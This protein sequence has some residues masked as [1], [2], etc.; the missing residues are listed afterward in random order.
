MRSVAFVFSVVLAAVC[1]LLQV[2]AADEYKKPSAPQAFKRANAVLSGKI[3]EVLPGKQRLRNITNYCC[4][5]FYN[6]SLLQSARIK[7]EKLYRR[8]DAFG[9]SEA[10]TLL[11]YPQAECRSDFKPG[12]DWLFY[13]RYDEETYSWVIGD[14][15]RSQPISE[16]ID[17]LMFFEKLPEALEKTRISGRV[18]QIISPAT[19]TT[20]AVYKPLA[21]MEIVASITNYKTSPVT[22]RKILTKTDANGFYEFY[23]LPNEYVG[24]DLTEEFK[25][26]NTETFG[27]S[28]YFYKPGDLRTVEQ[29]F[30]L[31]TGDSIIKGKILDENGKPAESVKVQLI[32]VGNHTALPNALAE[33]STSSD[34]SKNGE[35]LENIDI[36]FTSRL[37]EKTIS[38]RVFFN[39]GKPAE[40]GKVIFDAILNSKHIYNSDFNLNFPFPGNSDVADGKFSIDALE[41]ISG[42][43]QAELLFRRDVLENCLKRKLDLP[44]KEKFVLVNSKPV[45]LTVKE[46]INDLDLKFLIPPCK[47]ATE[48]E[49]DKYWAGRSRLTS[50]DAYTRYGKK[51]SEEILNALPENIRE[52]SENSTESSGDFDDENAPQIALARSHL[53]FVGTVEKIF[54]ETDLDPELIPYRASRVSLYQAVRVKIDKLFK[55][56]DIYG[57]EP[58]DRVL[59]NGKFEKDRKMLF[60]FD[61]TN[62]HFFPVEN[63]KSYLRS[64]ESPPKPNLRR[65]SGYLRL[66]KNIS[67][68]KNLYFSG[69]FFYQP[70][71]NTTVV[72]MP[73][74][75]SPQN[76]KAF[77]EKR[78]LKAV[79]DENGFYEFDNLPPADYWVFASTPEYHYRHGYETFGKVS[80]DEKRLGCLVD[81]NAQP[82]AD[83]NFDVQYRGEIGGRVSDEKGNPVGQAMLK[84]FDGNTGKSLDDFDEVITNGN[85][86]FHFSGLPDGKYLIAVTT[87]PRINFKAAFVPTFHPDVT[88]KEKAVPVEIIRGGKKDG[89]NIAVSRRLPEK[90]V[91]G[92]VELPNANLIKNNLFVTFDGIWEFI[93]FRQAET[94]YFSRS[95]TKPFETK[96]GDG[97]FSA[98]IPAGAAGKIQAYAL[99]PAEKAAACLKNQFLPGADKNGFVKIYSVPAE[100]KIDRNIRN[101]KLRFL[102]SPACFGK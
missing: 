67:D 73:K 41:S 88:E 89:I 23:D 21:G 72:L 58:G 36:R 70:L 51:I 56:A 49:S 71:G 20:K 22:T 86:D 64:F 93:P 37:T 90:T 94:V 61:D 52:T 92:T 18:R 24:V 69:S 27:L 3:I 33:V 95:N 43:L 85:G 81:L 14:C 79:T 99:I 65:I 4:N 62:R 80:A 83:V 10:D 55:P 48:E 57:I 46:N 31:S 59:V 47:P 97:K 38:G 26:Y 2:N 25:Y 44:P 74:D 98:S 84:L 12:E 9:I 53:A 63:A 1:G 34:G 78:F 50:R 32:P 77:T 8:S 6:D 45:Y 100:I 96:V 75:N 76:Q 42:K 91:S 13:L 60:L 16:A 7:I 19:E 101:I 15:Y 54:P 11:I 39:N 30:Y 17:D 29:N 87:A 66:Q 35:M 68:R 40:S 102:V 5:P 82:E 28:D